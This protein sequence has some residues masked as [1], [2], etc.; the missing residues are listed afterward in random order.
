[1][2]TTTSNEIIDRR[3]VRITRSTSKTDIKI[4][5]FEDGTHILSIATFPT[6]LSATIQLSREDFDRLVTM[7][8]HTPAQ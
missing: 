2:S 7:I 5:V 4:C 1:M 6:G 8:G 3:S